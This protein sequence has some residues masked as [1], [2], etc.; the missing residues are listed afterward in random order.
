MFHTKKPARFQ[1]FISMFQTLNGVG[2]GPSL[3]NNQEKNPHLWCHP[4]V[5]GVGMAA[6]VRCRL[7]QALTGY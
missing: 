7:Y 4:C 5:E 3:E 1:A 6:R 2:G